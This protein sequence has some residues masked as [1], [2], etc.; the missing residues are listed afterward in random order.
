MER[1]IRWLVSYARPYLKSGDVNE[2]LGEMIELAPGMFRLSV[3]VIW[4]K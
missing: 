1:N 4:E 2:K 3:E